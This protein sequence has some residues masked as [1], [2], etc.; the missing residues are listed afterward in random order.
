VGLT[1]IA[2]LPAAVVG[3]EA[4]VRVTVEDY[5]VVV[6]PAVKAAEAASSDGKVRVLYVLG[7]EFPELTA[8]AAWEATKLAFGRARGWERIAVVGDAAWLGWAIRVVGWA[9]PGQIRVFASD[10]LGDARGWVTSD[11]RRVSGARRFFVDVISGLRVLNEA[12]H[13]VAA[14]VFGSQ[15][16]WDS[17]LVT[18]IVFASVVNGIRRVIAAPARRCVRCDPAR[19]SLATRSSL[20]VC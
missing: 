18:V 5:E 2:G 3:V 11:R 19:L 20:P 9:M 8:G 6:V 16:G 15:K 4:H 12:R 1:R 17:N 13:R 7:R 10:Q 14:V